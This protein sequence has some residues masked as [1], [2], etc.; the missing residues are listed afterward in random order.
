MIEAPIKQNRRYM[1]GHLMRWSVN[2][3]VNHECRRNIPVL[4]D[5][6]IHPHCIAGDR[7]N[8]RHHFKHHRRHPHKRSLRLGSQTRRWQMESRQAYS[9]V[10]MVTAPMHGSTSRHESDCNSAYK[11]IICHLLHHV[12]TF[13]KSEHY[14]EA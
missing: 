4:N 10:Y 14:C 3:L 1:P 13:V 7:S 12:T 5:V 8:H 11:G 9:E 2:R 6:G